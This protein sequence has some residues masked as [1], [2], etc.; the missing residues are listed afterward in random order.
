MD[1]L[2]AFWHWNDRQSWDQALMVARRHELDREELIA[3]AK[4]EG[5]DEADIDTLLREAGGGQ[6]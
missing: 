3:Y 6:G 2:A 1:R 4:D 5:S